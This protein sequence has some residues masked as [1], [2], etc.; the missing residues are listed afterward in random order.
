MAVSH[1][2]AICFGLV[3]IPVA[4]YTATQDNDIRFNQL[5]KDDNSR[6]RYKKTCASCGKELKATDIVK[7]FEYAKDQYV[8]VTDEDFEAIKTEKDRSI[9]ILHFADLSGIPPI[10]Y[11]KTYQVVPETG[12]EKAFELLRRS[13]LNKNKVAIGKTVLG[14]KESLLSILPTENGM[15]VETMF[16]ADEIKEAPKEIVKPEISDAELNM[17]ETLISSMD[18]PF[19]ASLYKDEYQERLK[20]LIETKIAGKEVVAAQSESHD[21]VIDLM[22]ALKASITAQQSKPK[23]K[24]QKSRGVS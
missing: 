1:R 10:Y 16:F 11:D 15:L 4:L 19:D 7:G 5:C 14:N 8:I 12:S 13:M 6:V 3:H 24:A 18:K 17:A 21:N 2:G 20:K 22:Q 9:Q 23:K